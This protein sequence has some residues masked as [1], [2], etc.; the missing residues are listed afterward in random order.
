VLTLPAERVAAFDADLAHLL[1]ERFPEP[2][3][4]AHR[5]F[6]IVAPSPF[7]VGNGNIG[8]LSNVIAEKPPP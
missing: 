5:V 2:L 3:V 4:V 1:A 6:G 7:E 8:A